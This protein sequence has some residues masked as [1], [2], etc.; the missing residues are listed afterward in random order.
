MNQQELRHLNRVETAAAEL[1][2]TLAS[3]FSTL[4]FLAL[5]VIPQLRLTD[6]GLVDVDRF[7]LLQ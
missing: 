7:Q 4:S 5:P 6:L 1:G 3:P 2:C